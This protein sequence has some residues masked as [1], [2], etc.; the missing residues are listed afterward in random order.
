MTKARP[1][2]GPGH[3][4]GST[5]GSILA[6]RE[7]TEV[8]LEVLLPGKRA[9]LSFTVTRLRDSHHRLAML[10]ALGLRDSAL[11]KASG[12]SQQRIN[13][14]RTVPAFIEL[15]AQYRTQ[16]LEGHLKVQLDGY[17]EMAITNMVRAERMIADT[18]EQADEDDSPPPLRDLVAISSDRADRF[19]FPKGSVNLNVNTDFA[20]M[21]EG[22]I[23]RTAKVIELRPA[24][25]P[26]L[27]GEGAAGVLVSSPAAPAAFDE[28]RSERI[29][30]GQAIRR[31]L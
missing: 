8:D 30:A 7:L 31:R 5:A 10:C 6:I 19:G 23:K 15:V 14:L 29:A 13:G 1:G 27:A 21:L 3:K 2:V 12:Y 9:K 17:A 25:Q 11:T 18:L 4:T 24:Q 26:S 20:S 28:S 16:V 22:A